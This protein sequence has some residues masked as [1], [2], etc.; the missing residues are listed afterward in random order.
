MSRNEKQTCEELIDPA[1]EGAMWNWDREVLIGPGRVNLTGESMYDD[2]QQIVADYVL[3]YRNMP[4]A[5]LEAK[6]EGIDASDGIQQGSRYAD[7]LGVRFS[8]ASN[9]REYI[10]TDNETQASESFSEP[11]PPEALLELLGLDID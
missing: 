3:R 4:L 7:R 1:L 8:I 10:L 2:S 9:G 11:L 6:A 5:I